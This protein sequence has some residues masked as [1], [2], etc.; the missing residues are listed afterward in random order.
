M[1]FEAGENHPISVVVPSRV[2]HAY[3][4][5][6][7]QGGMVINL[8]DKLYKGIGKSEDVDEIRYENILEGS[9]FVLD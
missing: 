6:S 2:V 5:V 9:P 4:C 3:K 8:P 7:Q 1:R